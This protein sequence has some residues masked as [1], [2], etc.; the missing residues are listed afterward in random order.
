MEVPGFY[1][2]YYAT[3]AK[4]GTRTGTTDDQRYGTNNKRST[5]YRIL[6]GSL[7]LCRMPCPAGLTETV[8]H[9]VQESPPLP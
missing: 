1:L 6:L 3:G 4:G 5:E 9:R 2:V 8:S 7:E